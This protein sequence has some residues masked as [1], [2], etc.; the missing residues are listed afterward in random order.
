MRMMSAEMRHVRDRIVTGQNK[1]GQSSVNI[2][3]RFP[4]TGI[5]HLSRQSDTARQDPQ[6]WLTYFFARSRVMPSTVMHDNSAPS[7]SPLTPNA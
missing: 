6:V 7:V 5:L 3:R 2:L 1:S 4:V